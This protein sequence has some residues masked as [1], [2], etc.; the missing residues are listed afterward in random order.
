M[1]RTVPPLGYG[2]AGLYVALSFSAC[3]GS[4][5][6]LNPAGEQASRISG[7]WWFYLAVL[8]GVFTVVIA[9]MLIAVAI[10]WRRQEAFS[11]G[12]LP[13]PLNAT[14]EQQLTKVVV[15]SVAATVVILFVLLFADFFTGRAVS[16]PAPKDAITINITGHQWW[17]SITYEDPVP[18]KTVSTANELHIPVG[19]PIM[20]KLH[21]TDVIHSFWI[22]NLHGKKDLIP[23]HPTST[24]FTA[25]QAGTYHG[26]CAEFCGHQHA[27]MGLTI[28]AEAPEKFAAWLEGQRQS[29][30][31]PA[32]EQQRRGQQVFLGGT[33]VMCHR[34]QGTPA[35]ATVGPDLTH[36][37]SRHRIAAGTLPNARGWLAGWI[38]DPQAH[39]PGARMPQHTFAPEELNALLDYLETLK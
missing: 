6:S 7:L 34:I 5:S 29:A 27:H 30:P 33:C 1:R 3:S 4:Q 25:N 37:A 36:F 39:K 13:E 15:A 14:R 24:W 31:N 2:L 38:L 20:F 32:T 22:P 19:R 12:M 26:Q 16:S 9:A 18:S 17:W 28:T 10:H 8:V 23:G 35:M 21:S 11:P